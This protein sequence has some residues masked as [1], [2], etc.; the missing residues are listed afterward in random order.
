[1]WTTM[2]FAS[3]HS[4]SHSA[5]GLSRT[6]R[7]VAVAGRHHDRLGA[8]LADHVLDNRP[9]SL[10]ERVCVGHQRELAGIAIPDL[11]VFIVQELEHRP[12]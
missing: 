8:A 2:S 5:L 12:C 1:M 9:T 6:L 7:T 3:A 11:Q 4:H 10:F